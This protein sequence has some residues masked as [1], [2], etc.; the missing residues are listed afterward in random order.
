MD[1]PV[2]SEVLLG[3][4]LEAIYPWGTSASAARRW[5]TAVALGPVLHCLQ[6]DAQRQNPSFSLW[7]IHISIQQTVT[8]CQDSVES[9]NSEWDCDSNTSGDWCTEKTPNKKEY[10]PLSKSK[11]KNH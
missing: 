11:N 9:W 6:H 5:A 10:A 3:G 8:F 7:K 4:D 1:P 2:P